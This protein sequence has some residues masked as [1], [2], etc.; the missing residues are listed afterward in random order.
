VLVARAPK[1]D[2]IIVGSLPL[3]QAHCRAIFATD[4]PEFELGTV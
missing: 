4:A 2:G 1:T 3:G